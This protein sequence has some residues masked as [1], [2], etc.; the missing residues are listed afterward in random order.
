MNKQKT[1]GLADKKIFNTQKTR[2]F[3]KKSVGEKQYLAKKIF[4]NSF[5]S[6]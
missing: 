5:V 6:A 3:S 1:Q 2:K 4:T